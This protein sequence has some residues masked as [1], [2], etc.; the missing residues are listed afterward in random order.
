MPLATALSLVV[1]ACWGVLLVTRGV[2]R[3][4][5]AVLGLLAALGLVATVVAAVARLPDQRARGD[6]RES[7]SSGD[8]LGTEL[9][10]VVLGRRRAGPA[11]RVVA[12]ALAVRWCPAWPEMGSRYDAP[13]RRRPSP[14]TTARRGPHRTSTCGR[15]WTRVA[16]PPRDR[17]R[18]HC[19]PHDPA[20]RH[21]PRGAARM[22]DNHGNTPA[23]WTAV[24]V[25]ML[26]F[27]V[28]GVGLMLDPV[29]MTAVLGRLRHRRRVARRVR[30][31]GQDG[32]QRAPDH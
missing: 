27:V 22:S 32:P 16:T 11:V 24:T 15:R 20:R 8:T 3:R 25:A 13:G 17:L 1:L 19:A 26:G 10:R 30:R 6:A 14:P 31:D 2:V 4:V 7:A 23:A 12:T 28:G 21:L 9:D 5:V 18:I 29:S